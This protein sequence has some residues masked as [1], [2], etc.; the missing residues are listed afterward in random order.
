MK[1]FAQITFCFVTLTLFSVSTFAIPV[2]WTDWQS[3]SDSFSASGDITVGTSLIAV[4]YSGSGA[5]NFVQ[6]GSGTNYW[7]G[8]AYTNG[9]VDN[10]PTPAELVA[11]NSGGTVTITFSEAILNPYIAM[12]SWNNNVVEFGVPIQIDSFGQGYWGNGTASLNQAGTGF[13]GNGEFHGLISLQG[14]FT[15]ITFTHTGEN[16]HGFTVG[17]ADLAA[18]P[19]PSSLLLFSLGIGLAGIGFIRKKQR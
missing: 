10:A 11:L 3:S 18:V 4:D 14:S 17:V 6:T 9:T 16:W 19:E 12:N 1:R 13:T 5:H 15:S 2:F 7:S 8:T